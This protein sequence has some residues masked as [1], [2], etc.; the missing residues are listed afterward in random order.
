MATSST[1]D[2]PLTRHQGTASRR[3]SFTDT[4]AD[5]LVIAA[6]TAVLV[7]DGM[8]GKI[9]GV[10]YVFAYAAAWRRWPLAS[11]TGRA[12]SG[13]GLRVRYHALR[14]EVTVPTSGDAD[15]TMKCPIC[16]ASVSCS[17]SGS[18]LI[19]CSTCR[20]G[21]FW[22][23]RKCLAYFERGPI[24]EAQRDALRSLIKKG[25][26][27]EDRPVNHHSIESL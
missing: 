26:G 1:S 19:G 2:G 11:W 4:S 5:Q 15:S 7:Y 16:D 6:T 21:G 3:G 10:A 25:V 14:K 18:V 27:A 22:C 9:A 8:V 13:R 23:T 20:A 24:N 12:G 17:G